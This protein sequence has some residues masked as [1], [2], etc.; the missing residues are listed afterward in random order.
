MAQIR[1]APHIFLTPSLVFP[2]APLCTMFSGNDE[3]VYCRVSPFPSSLPHADLPSF[4]VFLPLPPCGHHLHYFSFSLS[5]VA[6]HNLSHQ[7]TAIEHAPGKTTQGLSIGWTTAPWRPTRG[8]GGV[9]TSRGHTVA[10]QCCTAV[11]GH[12]HCHFY[13]GINFSWP[14]CHNGTPLFVMKVTGSLTH[15]FRAK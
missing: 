7:R 9:C 5:V 8:G 14:F 6:Q 3:L 15:F 1:Q 11:S 2:A 13:M 10:S 4:F 12:P